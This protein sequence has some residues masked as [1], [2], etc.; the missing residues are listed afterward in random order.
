VIG[1]KTAFIPP[2]GSVVEDQGGAI[3]HWDVGR[4]ALAIILDSGGG[5]SSF[6]YGVIFDALSRSD[7]IGQFVRVEGNFLEGGADAFFVVG[8]EPVGSFEVKEKFASS[9]T[10]V[11][12]YCVCVIMKICI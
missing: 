8:G 7:Q 1:Q 10:V 4:I 12:G 11:H 5:F 9:L 3:G 2:N 6:V